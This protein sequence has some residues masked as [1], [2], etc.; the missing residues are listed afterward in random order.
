MQLNDVSL[1]LYPGEVHSLMG[2]NRCRK[3]DADED[4]VRRLHR[5]TP[6]AGPHGGQPVTITPARSRRA[7]RRR[8]DHQ[9]WR[10]APASRWREHLSRPRL[11]SGMRVA[12][13]EMKQAAPVSL[14]RLG[15]GFRRRHRVSTLSIAER[16]LVEITLE[17]PV[18]SASW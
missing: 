12:R 8:G 5:P 17:P 3:I 10:C 15:A 2:E 11:R 9:S 1:T 13:R 14:G 6:T 7:S 4:P 18:F 16:Q